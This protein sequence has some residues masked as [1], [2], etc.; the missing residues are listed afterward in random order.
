MI[1]R[2]A[3]PL[4]ALLLLAGWA[5]AQTP[6]EDVRDMD[7][8]YY[9]ADRPENEFF[10]RDL[11]EATEIERLYK[12]EC[13][14]Y[15]RCVPAPA[16]KRSIVR[17]SCQTQLYFDVEKQICE[18]KHKVLNCEQIDK[19]HAPKP[20]WPVPDGY[21][22]PCPEGQ[23]ECGSGECLPRSRFCDGEPDCGDGSDE[24]ICRHGEDPN[25]ADGCDPRSCRWEQGCFCSVDGTR[26]PG[27]LNPEQTPQMITITFTGAV[28][29]R[30]FRI[31]QDIFK[32]T[33]KHK[34]NDCTPKGTFFISHAFTN[35]SAVQELHRLGHE[36]SV[37]SITNTQD[38]EYWTNLDQFQ[39]EAEMD[40]LR[41]MCENFAN[42]TA[43]E[44]LGVRVPQQRVGGNQQ[45]QMMVDWG[46][47]Y[48]SSISA[49]RSRVPLWPYTLMHRIPHRCIGTDQNC[50][51]KN[52]TVWEMVINE[53]DRRDDPLFDEQLTGCHY[54]DQC[55]N[56]VTPKQFRSFLDNNLNHHFS[57]NR[58]P[59]GLHFTSGYFETRRDFLK[60]FRKWVADT[61]VRG[62]FY[63]VTMHQVI[64]WM[65]APTE[66][67]AINNFQEWKG[68]CEVKGLPY[69]S[70][71]NPC[72]KKVPRLFP[73]EEEMY[74]YT[75]MDCPN[76]Y[77]W[78]GD[79]T[80]S[81]LADF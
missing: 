32:D 10:R 28:N 2:V 29:E 42:I 17:S 18:R 26:I 56:L 36:I 75:C 71:P 69:C 41:I 24:N 70:L 73:N 27:D 49:P 59:F 78:L 8:E 50:P 35:Y 12:A 44:I 68:K 39:Y 62:D 31:F 20:V 81:G 1:R 25:G 67:A 60:E 43:N 52:F 38:A 54:V 72:P 66:I 23:I 55:A 9:C 30:N 76:S 4:L 74:L 45:F 79:P 22:S 11:G 57:K 58:A 5:A 21:Q 34:G 53:L 13:G 16:G 15:Y 64:S 6:N 65:E 80:G 47:L 46:F 37:S 40:G 48:D 63:F 3:T 51:S 77:P 7:P 19:L 14:K 33:V 61:A